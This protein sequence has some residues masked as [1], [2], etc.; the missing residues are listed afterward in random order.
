MRTRTLT[1][2]YR[3]PSTR[4]PPEGS[5]SN[6]PHA[7]SRSDCA[8]ASLSTSVG[9]GHRALATASSPNIVR[10]RCI[11]PSTVA[12]PIRVVITSQGG[13]DFDPEVASLAS[14]A[15][16]LA[17]D[18]LVLGLLAGPGLA[19][20]VLGGSVI[21]SVLGLV[22]AAV[23]FVSAAVLYARGIS[24]TGRW[25]GNRLAGTR[26][27]DVRTGAALD[28]AHAA[29]RFVVRFLVSPVLGFGYLMALG[30]RQRRT[31]HDSIAGSVVTRPDRQTWSIDD[32]TP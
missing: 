29:T 6:A 11:P 5:V 31:F 22:L 28:T 16:G 14:R 21:T 17:V 15:I 30:N 3:G 12:D 10:S 2:M 19:I 9:C 26:V 23:G 13:I 7:E 20:A 1:R 27:V 4:M 18:A 24:T 8:S 32:E 25:L